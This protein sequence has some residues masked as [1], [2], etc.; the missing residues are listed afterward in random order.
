[1][2]MRI[3]SLLGELRH[4][5]TAKRIRA[6]SGEHA[7]VDSTRAVLVWEPRRVCPSY[8]VPEADIRVPLS[9][10]DAAADGVPGLLHPGIPFAVHSTAGTPISVGGAA[11]FRLE[12]PDLAGYVE[13]DFSGFDRW[14][15]ED[16]EIFGH[17][18]DPFHRVDVRRSSRPVRIERDGEVLAETTRARMLFE[19]NLPTRYYIPREDV[20]IELTPSGMQSY[21]P[22]KGHA[23]Y[24]ADDACWSYEDPLPEVAEVAGLV[25]FW[26]EQ[27]DVFVDGARLGSPDGAVA[28]AFRDEF[29]LR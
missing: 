25:A 29:G 26:N 9:A 13:L 1:M 19:T 8:A 18:R 27:V 23:S 12:D 2:S 22:Y 16:E 17:P 21:C 7:V 14:L 4:E 28:D 10:A 5:P 15:E 20:R 3:P 11:G 24:W 6:F